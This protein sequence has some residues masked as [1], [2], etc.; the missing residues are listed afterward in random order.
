MERAREDFEWV[1]TR[2]QREREWHSWRRMRETDLELCRRQRVSS[3]FR[4]W[5]TLTPGYADEQLKRLLANAEETNSSS[6]LKNRGSF[7]AGA[8][9]SSMLAAERLRL[10][11][12]RQA[13]TRRLKSSTTS[14][15]AA[16]GWDDAD[17][18]GGGDEVGGGVE[19]E[20]HVMTTAEILKERRLMMAATAA[21]GASTGEKGNFIDFDF[22]CE[23]NGPVAPASTAKDLR[24]AVDRKARGPR[25]S[26][27]LGSPSVSMGGDN[28]IAGADSLMAEKAMR[29]TAMAYERAVQSGKG[30]TFSM[31]GNDKLPKVQKARM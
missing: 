1:H 16:T 17:G 12:E 23:S 26:Q 14:S 25:H 4:A 2:R 7:N 9:S 20:W 27:V 3:C 24:A 29:L 30:S 28:L 18:E 22:A 15:A 13:K 10:A 21:G 31:L 11:R 6:S 5:W 8:A 19:D